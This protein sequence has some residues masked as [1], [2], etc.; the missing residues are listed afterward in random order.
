V[1]ESRF[2]RFVKRRREYLEDGLGGALLAVALVLAGHLDG[3]LAD[4]HDDLV[5]LMLQRPQLVLD[6]LV[7]QSKV[8][9]T[10]PTQAQS[11]AFQYS[12][13]IRDD[14][15]QINSRSG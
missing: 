7:A 10:S 4:R 8:P 15:P 6:V 2:G 13:C 9:T 1:S 11:K 5:A 12:S 3:V 14:E